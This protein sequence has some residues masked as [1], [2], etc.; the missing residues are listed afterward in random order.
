MS[1][2]QKSFDQRDRIPE[3]DKSMKLEAHSS[4]E[5]TLILLEIDVDVPMRI[6]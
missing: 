6:R 1:L 2:E 5:I 4:K 3:I